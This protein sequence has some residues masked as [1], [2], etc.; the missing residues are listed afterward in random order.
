[1][2]FFVN[3]YLLSSNSS[4]EHAEIKRLKFF[5]AHSVAAKLVTRDF[6]NIIHATLGRFGLADD[7]L[8]NMF[9]FF[10]GTTDYQGQAY[11][12]ADLN[13]PID[14]QVSSGSNSR[15]VK[16]GDRL[17]AEVFFIGGTYGLVDHVDYY[18]AAGN[19]TLRAKY[20]IRGF[21]AIDIFYGKNNRPYYERYY[22]PD[23]SC[24]ME[25]YYVQSTKD[26]P[27]NSFNV[28]KGYQGKDWFFDD[29]ESLFSF[30]LRELNDQ[31][32]GTNTF[33]ADRPAMAIQPVQQLGKTA[34]KFLWLP[35]S[36]IDDGQ[37]L[38][39]GPLNGFLSDPL[40]KDLH[41]WDGIIVMTNTQAA[42]L[43]KR[44]G[45]G[46]NIYT[47]NGSQA[48]PATQRIPMANRTPGQLVY[49]GRL[50][51]D[52][53]TNLLI[54]YFAKVH[55]A[56]RQSKLTFYG[57]GSASDT[58][59]YRDR[60]K[61]LKLEKAVTLAGYQPKLAQAYDQAQLFVDPGRIDGQPL[62]MAEALAHGV[63]VVSFDYLYGPS[64]YVQDGV[65]GKL[66]PLDDP[67]KFCATIIDLLKDQQELQRLSTGAYE[68]C[69]SFDADHTW[70]QWQK[71]INK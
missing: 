34:R 6:D 66:I 1:M 62:A 49:V 29:F 71:I 17:V 13:L 63:P 68:N 10:A 24:Y 56:V 18:D 25:R 45:R 4:I 64:E 57:Y 12:V 70:A 23:K 42:V 14:Y 41:K 47:I 69:Q 22:R 28:L 48:S 36:H 44:L 55:Q 9:D 58:Q 27:I 59:H 38:I 31:V 67:D 60:I 20:D 3:Q 40:T 43:Q 35:I 2:Y 61:E 65:N 21:K 15:T 37:D 53:G 33:I 54:D 11:H 50:G 51:N 19:T 30:F 39:N 32:P 8:V 46:A 5:K 7:Q 16:D 26:T 52:K